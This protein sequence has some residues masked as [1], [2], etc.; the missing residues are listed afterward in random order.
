MSACL[1]T[2]KPLD[3]I[4]FMLGTNDCNVDLQLSSKDIALGMEKL[5][6]KTKD[7]TKGMQDS[8]MT[9]ASIIRTVIRTMAVT[10]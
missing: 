2:H 6:V 3:Y 4:V 8:E 5:I 10:M 7:V 9:P 1:H